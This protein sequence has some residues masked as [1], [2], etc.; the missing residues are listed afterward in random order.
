MKLFSVIENELIQ[1]RPNEV[2]IYDWIE[3]YGWTH[4]SLTDLSQLET[5][6][7]LCMADELQED[8][9]REFEVWMRRLYGNKS[10][11]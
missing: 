8:I 3:G 5:C 9:E 11:A 1:S 2:K 4:I 6:Q 10:R 7:C